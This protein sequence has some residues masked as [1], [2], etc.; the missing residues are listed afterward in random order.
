MQLR[1]VK[2]SAALLRL[3]RIQPVLGRN[4]LESEDQKGRDHV[5][6]LSYGL[7]QQNFGGRRDIVG[8]SVS[9]DDQAMTVVGILPPDFQFPSAQTVDL[10]TPLGKDTAAELKR[11]DAMTANHDV[12]ARLKPG[13]T[14][15]QARAEMAVIESRIAPPSFMP[16]AQLSVRVLPLHDRLV[17]NV[18]GALI[19]LSCAVA[20]LLLLAC[21]NIANLLLSRAASRQREMAVRSALGASR[22]RLAQQLL[23]EC[24]LLAGLGCGGGVA[25]AFG[26][27]GTLLALLP[28]AIPGLRSLP[29][30]LRVLGFALT[31]ACMS[32]LVFGLGPALYSARTSPGSERQ[33]FTGGMRQQ[34]WLNLLASAQMAIAIVLLTGGVL[35]LQSFWKLRYQDLGFQPEHLLAMRLQISRTHYPA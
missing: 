1:T 8:R 22:R 6:I 9:I 20:F 17:G 24:L 12:I 11:G 2:A 23:V 3:L 29:I 33:R 5:A 16:N 19:A 34:R 18:R 14:L 26:T 31:G 27:R 21:A 4:F 7:W 32:A 30:D 13:V 35:M 25:L 28:R 15:E 10:I